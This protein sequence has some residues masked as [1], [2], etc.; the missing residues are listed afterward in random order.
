MVQQGYSQNSELDIDVTAS[1]AYLCML[2]HGRVHGR[3]LSVGLNSTLSCDTNSWHAQRAKQGLDNIVR[4]RGS[5]RSRLRS[6]F[7]LGCIRGGSV[8]LF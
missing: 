6:S 8:I 5:C 3:E 1:A 2:L 7:V 4:H